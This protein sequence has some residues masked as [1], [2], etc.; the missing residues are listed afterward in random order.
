MGA[1]ICRRWPKKAGPLPPPA[2][3]QAPSEAHGGAPRRAP[4]T[5]H[6]LALL[7]AEADQEGT[8]GSPL[9]LSPGFI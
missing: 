9:R 1:R 4:T 2:E 6:A 7:G 5:G 3:E 8:E